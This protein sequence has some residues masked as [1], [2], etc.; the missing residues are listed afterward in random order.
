MISCI[1]QRLLSPTLLPK[2]K[3]KLEE[4][5]QRESAED[6]HA[7]KRTFKTAELAQIQQNLKLT[8]Q[9]MVLAKSPEQYEAVAEV[10]NNL[11]QQETAIQGELA[12]I[13]ARPAPN[14]AHSQ[15]KAALEFAED[16]VERVGKCE[17]FALARQLFESTN[18]KLFLSF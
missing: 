8:S 1:R 4:L 2:L 11:K 15:V 12:Q 16:L 14:E 6:S 5:A 10:F 17:D 7:K 18:A 13:Q 9:N 3:Q